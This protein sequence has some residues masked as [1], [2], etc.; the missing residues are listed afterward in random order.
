M[1]VVVEQQERH[2]QAVLHG[3]VNLHAV[4]EERAVTR[5]NDGAAP[6]SERDTERGAEAV[7]HAAHAQRDDES[8]V[9]ASRQVVDRRCADVACV[10]DD[11]DT[12]RQRGVEHG[13][14]LAVAHAGP[15]MRRRLQLGPRHHVRHPHTCRPAVAVQRLRQQFQRSAQI[16]GVDV[17]ARH[18]RRRRPDRVGRHRCQHVV[19]ARR[20]RSRSAACRPAGTARCRRSRSRHRDAPSRRSLRAPTTIRAP[21]CPRHPWRR[22]RWPLAPAASNAAARVRRARRLGRPARLR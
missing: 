6:A 2:R 8:P 4:H 3:G 14:R 17:R 22:G 20:A 15:V 12:V 10:D 13:H 16:F 1:R 18:E 19:Q 11:V 7:S 9:P 21:A 5:D